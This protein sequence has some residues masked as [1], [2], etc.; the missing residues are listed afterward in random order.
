MT[1]AIIF[2]LGGVLYDIDPKLSAEAFRRLG[3]ADFNSYY[4]FKDQLTLFDKLEKG[5]VGKDEFCDSI[6][7]ISGLELSNEQIM[8][9]WNALLV[10]MPLENIRLLKELKL[11]Y[12][13]FLLSNTN[14]MHL[15]HIQAEMK[16]KGLKSLDEL[17][18]KAFYSYQMSMR[19]P[20]SEIF[21][22][23]I[24]Q[25]GLNAAETIFIDDGKENISGAEKVGIRSFLKDRTQPIHDFLLEKGFI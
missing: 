13:L 3:I 14:I 9:A 7:R 17:F 2:D 6:R 10:G 16:T 5:Q 1:T 23:V 19:K 22:E 21:D 24:K 8:E 11:K 18:E 4:S 15:E 20:D 12:K 25:S